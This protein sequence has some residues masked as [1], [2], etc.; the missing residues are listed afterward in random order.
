VV[1]L[2]GLTGQSSM[3]GRWLLDRTVKSGDDSSER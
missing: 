1:S 2:P 3:P